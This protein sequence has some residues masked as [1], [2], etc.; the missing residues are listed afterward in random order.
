MKLSV[1]QYTGMDE[2]EIL[3]FTFRIVFA[4][5]RKVF[6]FI[7]MDGNVIP[8]KIGDFFIKWSYGDGKPVVVL[9]RAVDIKFPYLLAEQK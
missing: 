3:A 9:A 7:D 1:V 4:P 5:E 2:S 6:E 8:I